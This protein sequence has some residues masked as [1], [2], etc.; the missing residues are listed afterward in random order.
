MDTFLAIR[1]IWTSRIINGGLK[2]VAFQNLIGN[3]E[4]KI[5][6]NEIIKNKNYLIQ[7]KNKLKKNEKNPIYKVQK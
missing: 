2:I 7:L 5:L 3:E 6:L 4:T 1:L